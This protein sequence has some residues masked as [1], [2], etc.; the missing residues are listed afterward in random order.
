[1]NVT[2]STT[3]AIVDRPPS[4][5]RTRNAGIAVI[6]VFLALVAGVLHHVSG[7]TFIGFHWW[8]LFAVAGILGLSGLVSGLSGFA[9]SAIG[10]AC[11]LLMPPTLAVPLLMA[12]SAANQCMSIGQLRADMPSRWKEIWPGGYG[13][14]VLGGVL[15]VPIG[16]WLLN[17]LPAARLMLVFGVILT[18][19]S[20]Y[21]L[22]KPPDL[23][24]K[25]SGGANIGM[26]VGFIG[27]TLGGFTAFPGAPVVIWTGLQNI[28]KRI[29][30]SIVQP[31][32]LVLQ[33]VSLATDV[34]THPSAFG[35]RFW[36]LLAILIPIVL[37][38][39]MTGVFLYRR[40]SDVNFKRISYILLGLSGAGLLIK[41][42]LT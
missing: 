20:V 14:Y 12:L 19:Y 2:E 32:I 35:M 33:L 9:F 38:G 30:R 5:T 22:L 23:K 37:P 29:T 18:V 28:P 40:M 24:M 41:A 10:S 39:T 34:Y 7:G 42:I 13:P 21:S 1:M 17:H 31:Y 11:L 15:G 26:T 3:K 27:G 6:A 8:Q 16:I 36:I 4:G 25:G